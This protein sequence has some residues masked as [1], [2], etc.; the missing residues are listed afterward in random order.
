RVA[1]GTRAR[2]AIHA[3]LED[4][5]REQTDFELRPERLRAAI[6]RLESASC[7]GA[8]EL[9]LGATL[10]GM[11]ISSTEVPLTKGLTIA[12]CDALEGL[13][14]A[15]IAPGGGDHADHLV[16]VLAVEEDDA[17]SAPARGRAVLR[18]LLRALRLFGDGRVMLGPLAWARIG[19]GTWTTVALEREVIAG[20]AA[21]HAGA[22][23]LAGEIAE[24]LRALL[25]DV[26]CGH[27]SPDLAALADELLIAPEPESGEEMVGDAAESEE[28]LDLII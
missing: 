12:Q 9:M 25:R 1:A 24:D 23:A 18:D 28:I 26:I 5:F 17:S 16:V 20:K 19:G 6:D 27:L 8:G 14:E 11:R 4:V 15:A 13:P 21:E 10:H 3:L 22:A 2:A 7:A